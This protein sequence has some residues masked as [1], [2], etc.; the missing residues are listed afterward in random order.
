MVLQIFFVQEHLKLKYVSDKNHLN[1]IKFIV[2]HARTVKALCILT[3][4][5]NLNGLHFEK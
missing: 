5:Q 2:M 4:Q 1:G 3:F